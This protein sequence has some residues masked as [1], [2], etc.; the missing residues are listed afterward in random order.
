MW[1]LQ[2]FPNCATT[3]HAWRRNRSFSVEQIWIH[4][5]LKE[6]YGYYMNLIESTWYIYIYIYALQRNTVAVVCRHQPTKTSLPVFCHYK[7]L[8]QG[9]TCR[10]RGCPVSKHG[11]HKKWG[12]CPGTSMSLIFSVLA[13]ELQRCSN[14]MALPHA[15]LMWSY[16]GSTIYV[17]RRV[18]RNFCLW[19][20]SGLPA[21][22]FTVVWARISM[23]LLCCIILIHIVS[24]CIPCF[25]NISHWWHPI[26]INLDQSGLRLAD[27][28]LIVAA[29]PCSLFGP[30]C[31]SI[32]RRSLL[33]PEGDLNNFKVRLARRIWLSFVLWQSRVQSIENILHTVYWCLLYENMQKHI[34]QKNPKESQKI[35]KDQKR[36]SL[37]KHIP[38]EIHYRNYFQDFLDVANTCL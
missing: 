16:H 15:G 34:P 10:R 30:A 17:P 20:R 14:P 8:F 12:K 5:V 23:F 21:A 29:P 25:C 6:F 18:S 3:P 32:H 13:G 19:G 1:C 31:S 36:Q 33:Q 7:I 24:R 37:Q 28:A 26:W 11:Y 38:Q 27:R 2:L 9:G 4:M 22:S 35:S